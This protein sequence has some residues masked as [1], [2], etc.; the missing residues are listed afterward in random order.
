[1][2]THWA[3][4]VKWGHPQNP[5]PHG[6]ATGG[7]CGRFQQKWGFPIPFSNVEVLSFCKKCQTVA[8]SHMFVSYS[9][10]IEQS[11][12][13]PTCCVN[14]TQPFVCRRVTSFCH[15][16]HPR[17]AADSSPQL[18]FLPRLTGLWKPP[19]RPVK[20]GETALH[21]ESLATSTCQKRTSI[22]STMAPKKRNIDL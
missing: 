5:R 1:M 9:R 12:C 17:T 22:F 21:R 13:H 11:N 16:P 3:S 2:E 6:S 7:S 14:T 15:K 19:K 20:N 4:E 10:Q 8:Q 18:A